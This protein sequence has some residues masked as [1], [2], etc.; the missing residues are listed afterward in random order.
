MVVLYVLLG[1][2]ML[3][4]VLGLFEFF[5][6]AFLVPSASQPVA[7]PSNQQVDL[8]L[9]DREFLILLNDYDPSWNGQLCQQMARRMNDTRFPLL[10]QYANGYRS[11]NEVSTLT[12][13]PPPR[14]P[15]SGN[16]CAF[17]NDQLLH[18][19]IV[20]EPQSPA[21]QPAYFSCSLVSTTGA[22]TCSYEQ[23]M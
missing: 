11:S 10:Q 13:V 7:F 21:Q 16:G 2:A 4:G 15:A 8:R 9:L 1:G 23:A 5:N 12:A 3:A 14:L 17:N 20:T 19:V 18:R 6:G 22:T